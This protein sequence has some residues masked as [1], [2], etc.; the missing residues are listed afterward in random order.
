MACSETFL[1]HLSNFSKHTAI[2]K[3]RRRFKDK[4][5]RVKRRK[6]SIERKR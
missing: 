1:K 2:K 3:T 6:P 5:R 4:D